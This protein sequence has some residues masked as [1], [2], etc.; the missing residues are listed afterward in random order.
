MKTGVGMHTMTQP[1]RIMM[2]P[3]NNVGNLVKDS[4]YF[5]NAATGKLSK[6]VKE[7]IQENLDKDWVGANASSIY[8]IGRQAK[9]MINESREIIAEC[10]RANPS[11]IYFTS[12]GT[13]G[14]NYIIKGLCINKWH[15]AQLNP[16]ITST[17]E[18]PSVSK[19]CEFL[20]RD[21]RVPVV[22]IEVDSTGKIKLNELVST[23]LKR[24]ASLV[25]IMC[26]NNE[27]GTVQ[28]LA[29]I[30][31]ICHV[32]K[33]SVH[34]DAIQAIGHIPFDV[35]DTKIDYLSASAHKFNGPKGVGF[36]YIK[37]GS[38]IP[39]PL[40]HGG[41]QEKGLRSGTE[42]ILGISAMAK[43][44]KDNCSQ[45]KTHMDKVQKLKVYLIERLLSANFP[46]LINGNPLDNE[47]YGIGIVNFSIPD[48]KLNGESLVLM[49]SAKL[50]EFETS[51]C[52]SAGS[53]CNS[54]SGTPSQVLMSLPGITRENA[55]RS[56]RISLAFDNNKSEVDCFMYKLYHI[57]NNY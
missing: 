15:G 9:T 18:H 28:P 31:D 44:L 53:A 26:V 51:I 7:L 21:F 49:M 5:D 6:C 8:S 16:I 37:K 1:V 19:V 12:G 29:D 48:S 39:S 20:H 36:I 4:I 25:S 14:N 57:L 30:V 22:Y 27:F 38:H 17:I 55:S 23:I 56:I 24:G 40:I 41:H 54:G 35:N 2:L 13:E 47:N 43:A 52:I 33:I 34:T 46:V 42:N 50:P 3:K 11:E 32:Y 10:I 45:L